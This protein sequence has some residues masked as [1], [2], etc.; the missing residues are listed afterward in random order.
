MF[1]ALHTVGV[2]RIQLFTEYFPKKAGFI[3]TFYGY[4]YQQQDVS[5]VK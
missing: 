1:W 4:G 5:L 3:I 2:I